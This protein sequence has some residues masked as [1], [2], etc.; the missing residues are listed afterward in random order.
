MR[1]E[2]V[3]PDSGRRHSLRGHVPALHCDPGT[4][5]V[6]KTPPS[7]LVSKKA[8]LES[9]L[10]SRPSSAESRDHPWKPEKVVTISGVCD[11]GGIIRQRAKSIA[12]R[13]EL[14]CES[15]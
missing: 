2:S 10:T 14:Q 7:V 13:V 9:G 11:I 6:A 1:F 4:L 5:V 8:M 12:S 3:L 15:S